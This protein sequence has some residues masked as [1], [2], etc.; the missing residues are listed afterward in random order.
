ME[1]RMVFNE[2]KLKGAFVIEIQKAED[3][4][5]Y[6]GRAWCRR[7]FE[8]HGL[9]AHLAQCNVSFSVK[10]GTLRGMHYQDPPFA[11]TKLVRCTAGAVYDV[12]VDL[13]PDSATF[14]QWTA[15]TLTADNGKMMYVPKGFA[16]G[17]LTLA[18]NCGVFYQT[19][20][21]FAPDHYRGVRWND[22]R[23][24]IA[25]PGEVTVIAKRDAEW[26]P[27]DSANFEPLRG[28]V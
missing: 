1:I 4:R 19:T 5:G 8:E 11:E 24:K 12:A 21:F 26:E 6:F 7:E 2:T 22:P 28:L 14:M 23:L 10:Q 17:F 16:H 15:A 9:D 13:R 25:W 3:E 18:D 27:C 20:E